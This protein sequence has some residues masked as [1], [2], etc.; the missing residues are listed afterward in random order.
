MQILGRV[1]VTLFVL[2]AP[3]L[4]PSPRAIAAGANPNQTVDTTMTPEAIAQSLVGPGV[5]IANVQYTGAGDARGSF[6]FTDAT[7]VGMAQGVILSSGNAHD[8]VGPNT[9]DSFSTDWTNPGDAD[10]DALSGFTTFD[11]AVLEFDFVPTANQVAFQYAFSSD[12]YPEWVNTQYNDVFAFFVNGINCA[13]VR[14][15][16]GDPAAPFVPVAVNN[17]N[18]SN[19]VQDPPPTPMRP[20]LFRANYVDPAGG[21]SLLDLEMDGITR[22]MTCQGAV[23]PGEVNHMKLAIADA[24]D[25]IY[26][27][28]VFIE[29]GSIVSNEN[30]TADLGLDPSKGPAPLDVTATIEGHDPNGL[31]LSYTIDWGDGTSTPSQ[32]LPDETALAF[33]TYESAGTYLVVL[34]VSNGTLTGKDDDDVEVTGG[35]TTTVAPTTTTIT[36][37][38]PTTTTSSSTITTTTLEPTTTSTS[39]T[40]TT[41]EPTTTSTSSTTTTLEPTT[42]ST[43]STTTLEPTTTSTSSTTT[44]VPPTQQY[45]LSV[46]VAGS[47][48]V[49]SSPKGINCGSKCSDSL[50]VGTS[51][52]LTAKPAN[53]HAFVGWTGACGGTS[54]TCTVLMLGDRTVGAAFN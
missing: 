51:V 10:L 14:Q 42:T 47:G 45:T 22:V 38:Q 15:V 44:T 36:T 43:S 8:V 52:T 41:L 21:P 2:G 40:T 31:P 18:D 3:L 28:N 4:V 53:K 19:P 35:T 7:V 30:P 16:A 26:D 1:I 12:E 11:A 17:V 32:S 13:E 5:A 50:T 27:S 25:G 29:A 9:S 33:H 20:D 6:A 54:P 37:L 48:K 49:T 24:S 34:T 23:I 39:S 46:T